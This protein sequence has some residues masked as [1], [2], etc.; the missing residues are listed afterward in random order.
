M[1][2][3]WLELFAELSAAGKE[4]NLLN[5]FKGIPL[6]FPAQIASIESEHISVHTDT[7]Q[8]VCMYLEKFTYIQSSEFPQIVRAEVFDL[9]A[10]RQIAVLGGF[11]EVKSDIGSRNLVRIQPQEPL[12]GQ[13][14]L[15]AN[16]LIEPGELADIS[17]NGLAV[18]ISKSLLGI[19]RLTK[20]DE[21]II[22]ME[23]PGTYTV[24]E[25]RID[26][27]PNDTTSIDRFSKDNI[28]FSPVPSRE[29]RKYE[30]TH[31]TTQADKIRNPKFRI[32][33]VIA[34]IMPEPDGDRYRIGM[35][36]MSTD[37][38]RSIITQFIAQRQSEIIREIKTL[39]DLLVKTN[40]K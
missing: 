20:G 11:S 21:L 2:G 31:S 29:S 40:E 34:N 24:G 8:A 17:Q 33:A 19:W 22:T 9:D 26:S 32:R 14:Q 10:R 35:R 25:Y 23:L 3:T 7:H 18:F 5:V 28:R 27:I 37:L 16:D 39:Y 30:Y 38:P 36:M 1:A 4:I 6:S 15:P 13:I 12:E